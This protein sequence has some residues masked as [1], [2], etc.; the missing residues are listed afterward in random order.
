MTDLCGVWVS[1]KTWSHLNI[2]VV[3]LVTIPWLLVR[4]LLVSI[5]SIRRILDVVLILTMHAIRLILGVNGL[6]VDDLTLD[7]R[8]TP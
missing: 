2:A 8:H 3:S 5:L 6:A 7:A 1:R 4:I